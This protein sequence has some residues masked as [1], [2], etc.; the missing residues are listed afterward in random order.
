MKC[1][2]LSSAC[3]LHWRLQLVATACLYLASKVQET[4]KYLRDVIKEAERR[5]WAKWVQQHP[6]D[7]GLWE[8]Q[9]RRQ[10]QLR[11]WGLCMHTSE[12]ACRIVAVSFCAWRQLLASSTGQQLCAMR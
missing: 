5:K 8:S 7:R 9:V 11:W 12:L 3:A 10:Q 4:P 6:A 2:S 1:L